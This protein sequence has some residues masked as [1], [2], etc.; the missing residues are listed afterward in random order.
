M[1]FR[2]LRAFTLI[3]KRLTRLYLV[4]YW[5]LQ[6]KIKVPMFCMR[7]PINHLPLA[8]LLPFRIY[9][10]FIILLHFIGFTVI[11]TITLQ[12]YFLISFP[13]FLLK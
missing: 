4:L 9:A 3:N 12:Q 6:L 13:A 11:Y 10:F 2:R 7:A 1:H 8:S 5:L